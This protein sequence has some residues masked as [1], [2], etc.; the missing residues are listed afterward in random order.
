MW[1]MKINEQYV[2]QDYEGRVEKSEFAYV[3]DKINGRLTG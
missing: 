2:Y 3:V 1:G